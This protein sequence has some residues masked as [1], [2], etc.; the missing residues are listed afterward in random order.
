[1]SASRRSGGV[2]LFGALSLSLLLVVPVFAVSRAVGTIDRRGLLGAS[3]LASFV[4]FFIY[5]SD[6]RRAEAGEWRIPEST[7]HLVELLG[8]WPGA[9]LAQRQFRHKT[10]KISFQVVF[11]MIVLLYQLIAFDSLL[12]WRLSKDALRLLHAH[13][14]YNRR[15]YLE[16]AL[17]AWHHSSVRHE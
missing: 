7:L 3:L 9:F 11:W 10:S 13:A 5:R 16:F 12:G 14:S 4:A 17:N 2:T 15:T 6:K 8:G 1:M